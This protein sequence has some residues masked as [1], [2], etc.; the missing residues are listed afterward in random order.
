MGGD[1]ISAMKLVGAA[2][3]EGLSLTVADVFRNPRLSD[4]AFIAVKIGQIDHPEGPFEPLSSLGVSDID[5]FLNYAISPLISFPMCDIIDVLP[6]TEFQSFSLS[7]AFSRPRTMIN[8]LFFDI[9][10]YLELGRLK[11]SCHDLVNHHEVLRTVF[12]FHESHYLQVILRNINLKIVEHSTNIDLAGFSEALCLR[13]INDEIPLGHPFTQFMIV[14]QNEKR[15]RL[16]LRL[17]HAQYDGVSL[18]QLW[19]DFQTA[20][21]RQPIPATPKFSTYLY[22]SIERSTPQSYDYW[23]R[24]LQ[25]SSMTKISS[26]LVDHGKSSA[27]IIE[28]TTKAV[29]M[30]TLPILPDGIT[31]A[32]VVRAAWSLVLAQLSTQSDVVFGQFIAGRNAA[33]P[34]VHKIVGP[35]VNVIPVRIQF[36]SE[37]NIMDLLHY[38][39]N[40]QIAN[41]PF[42]FLG[43]KDITRNC[44]N[45]PDEIEFNSILQ[46]QNIEVHPRLLLGSSNCVSNI[47]SPNAGLSTSGIWVLSSP[48]GDQ[49]RVDLWSPSN[50]LGQCSA[51]VL[52]SGLCATVVSFLKDPYA[53]V[54]FPHGFQFV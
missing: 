29:K 35:C 7:S 8:Y 13:D 27:R 23:R 11:Q 46:H 34:D 26:Y 47:F 21:Q 10:G 12:V 3:L 39:Q 30:I 43:F 1:S 5:V 48:H 22:N 25:G 9:D 16:I 15:H 49:L 54:P 45:W 20:F 37:W 6:T 17:S 4:M 52:V 31:T 38:T 19:C 18:P 53:A 51:N 24:L 42:E 41:A 14:K 32:T 2:R 44:T 50:I 33:I 40:Q 28:E 36:K